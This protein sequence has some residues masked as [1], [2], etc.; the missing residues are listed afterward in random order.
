LSSPL[1]NP[2]ISESQSITVRV[3]NTLSATCYDETTVNLIV[4]QQPIAHTIQ[5]DIVCDVDADGSHNFVLTDYNPQILNGQSDTIFEVIYFG[6]LTNAENNISPLP[7]NYLSTS[8]SET[9][10]TRI[11]NR[12]NTV[13]YAI[14]SFQ[15]GVSYLPI[16]YQPEDMNV[17]DDENNDGVA[18]FDLSIQNNAILNGQSETENI[19]T[20]HLSQE[21]AD[22][23]T[24]AISTTFTNSETPQTI[25]VRLENSNNMQCYST[26]SFNTVVVEKPVLLMDNQWPICEGDTVEIIADAGYDE[27]LWSTGETTQSII[28]DTPESYEVIVT[29][30]YGNLRCEDSMTVTVVQS[31]MAIIT[32]IETV[33]WSQSSNEIIVTVSGNGDYEYSIDGIYYQHSNHFTN[34]YAGEYTV[35][36]NDKNGCGVVMQEVYL[37]YYPKFFTPNND[38]YNDYWKLYGSN[39]EPDNIIYIYDRYGK[40]LKQ[41]SPT[42]IGWNGTFNG[43]NLPSS[44][45]WFLLERQ[46]GKQYR[47]HFTLK[48]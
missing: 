42:D 20:Y 46:N 28:V 24:N 44:D 25:Y 35:Y 47:G 7:S 38:G 31:D 43:N 13:C 22:V 9:L 23:N 18:E 32:N 17:C 1:P 19:I 11:H 15:I 29:N 33:D 21:D 12:N 45:Y 6:N 14:T 5:D 2:F 36:V 26:T 40:L 16:A 34:L 30:I 39:N 8:T 48:R 37:L 4:Y 3:E 41:L 10:Y 27:Y